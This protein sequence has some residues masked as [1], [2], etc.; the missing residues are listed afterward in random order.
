MP[1]EELS[2][3]KAQCE[4][5]HKCHHLVGQEVYYRLTNLYENSNVAW[6]HMAKD[7]S[8]FLPTVAFIRWDIAYSGQNLRLR[9]LALNATYT[10]GK[11][12]WTGKPLTYGG[13]YVPPGGNGD[14]LSMVIHAKRI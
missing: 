11:N 10:D 8:E 3:G 4:F 12:T 14:M 1:P 6:M 2:Q 5:Y 7:K 13:L 9:G